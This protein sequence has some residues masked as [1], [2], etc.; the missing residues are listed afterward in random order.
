L[1][2]SGERAGVRHAHWHGVAVSACE[3]CGRNRVPEVR[4]PLSFEAWLETP[5]SGVRMV[6]HPGGGRTLDGVPGAAAIEIAVGPE[7]GFADREIAAAEAAGALLV[8]A[9]PRVLRTETAGPALLAALNA[10][11]GD[12][13]ETKRIP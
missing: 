7:G 8:S 10:L 11:V 4:A 2:L 13:R 3:Q 6:L 12:W 9:G 1:K 5:P